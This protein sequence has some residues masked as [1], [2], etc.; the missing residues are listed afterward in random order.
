MTVWS[1]ILGIGGAVAIAVSIWS[2]NLAGLFGLGLAAVLVA[3][4]LWGIGRRRQKS[5]N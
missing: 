1:R 3:I 4:V 5:V 2:G